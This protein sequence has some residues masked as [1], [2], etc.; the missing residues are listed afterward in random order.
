[1]LQNHPTHFAHMLQTPDCAL[2]TTK[3]HNCAGVNEAF[4][5]LTVG[6]PRLLH[7]YHLSVTH[8]LHIL[9]ALPLN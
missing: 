2:S 4:V 8:Q 6:L 3:A 5:T 1:M 9:L 7:N